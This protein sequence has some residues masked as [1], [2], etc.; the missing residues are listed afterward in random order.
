MDVK[1]PICDFVKKYAESGNIRFHMP[2]HKGKSFIGAES[3]DITEID[4]A[5]V[6]YNPSGIIKESEEIA[7]SLFGTAK[8]L[9]STEG[10][11]LSIRAMLFLALL[12][13]TADGKRPVISAGRNAHKVFMTASA[14]LDFDID[15][16]Y[17]KKQS[18]IVSCVIT[19]EA[20]DVHLARADTKP[21][22][23]Y[24]TSPD[25]LG[26]I[27]DIRG[28]S[29]V[30][31]KHGVLLLVDNAHGA[32]LRFLPKSFHPINLGADMCCDSAHKTLPV[33]TGGAYLHISKC[34]PEYICKNAENAM[35]LFAST[36]PSYLILQSLDMANKYLSDG[37]SQKLARM[38][39]TVDSLKTALTE[40]GYQTVGNE[41]LKLTLAPKSFGYTGY[42]LAKLLQSE[43][44]VC[45]FCDPDYIT[46]MFT[47]ENS[48]DSLLRLKNVLCGIE[49]KP[50]ITE[51]APAIPR[52]VR[53]MTAREAMFAISE[54][55]DTAQCQG[56]ILASANIA[57]PPAIPV[58]V[59]GEVVDKAAIEL[60]E[61]YGIIECNVVKN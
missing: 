33:L 48:E 28:L 11:S 53:R 50:E 14:L 21:C 22:A 9:Y 19:P 23:V 29:Q 5:D 4:G 1:T 46:L 47:P 26:N 45:E 2:G 52:A 12:G 16:I 6:L 51:K 41:P 44:M 40:H 31:R 30:C 57:C 35:S 59:C 25:Y 15:W 36:S 34:A 13:K 32:Y 27:A 3:H 20:L 60:F 17:P 58:A 54:R 38:C 49:R 55:L 37:Y 7:S 8:T 24:I 42:E 61:Y 43:N 10:S 39:H 56:R 18:G